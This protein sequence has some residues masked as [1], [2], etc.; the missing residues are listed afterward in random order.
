MVTVSTE[1]QEAKIAKK[2]LID[3]ARGR[4]FLP[5]S[6]SYMDTEFDLTLDTYT[7]LTSAAAFAA[8][9]GGVEEDFVWIDKNNSPVPMTTEDL[10]GFIALVKGILQYGYV[11]A[12]EL[13]RQVEDARLI[14]EVEAIPEW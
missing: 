11:H 1:L 4:H 13:K 8:L 5:D 9:F 7:N 2:R 12:S 3:E 10:K 6:I 14:E